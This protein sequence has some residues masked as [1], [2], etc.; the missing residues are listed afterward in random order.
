MTAIEP[1]PE[2]S[3]PAREP[4]R[5]LT[6][7]RS[8]P[9]SDTSNQL[10]QRNSPVDTGADDIEAIAAHCRA[11]A[12]AARW[13]AERQR[14][15]REK[16]GWTD[17][18]APADPAIVEWADKLTDSFYWSNASDSAG[19]PDIAMLDRVGG[20]FET[21]AEA[22]AF[23]KDEQDR[24]GG[25]ERALKL[26]AEAQA[27]LRESLRNLRAPDDP[28]QLA[29]Y[30]WLRA[31]AARHRIF[32]KRFMRADDRADPSD[33]PCLLARIETA[34]GSRPQSQRQRAMLDDLRNRVSHI[35][36]RGEG[37]GHDWQAV[38]QAVEDIVDA[39]IPP[40]N[41]EL[42]DLLLPVIDELPDQDGLPPGFRLVTR[43][44]DRYLARRQYTLTAAALPI[45]TE[46]VQQAARVLAGRSVVL[47][48]G[49]RRPDAQKM[50]RAA[51][52]LKDLVWIE[53][54][55]HQSIG[56]FESAVARPD[57]ALVLLAIRWS[58]HA[59]GDV[60]QFCD[61][62]GKPL[63]R[64]PGG[65]SPNQVAAQI[66]MQAGDRLGGNSPNS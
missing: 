11:K 49:V 9:T 44:V 56:R 59:F 20:C 66:I 39:G 1:G 5:E 31:T 41:R 40:S 58:S 62:Y 18:D 65:Y 10:E 51:L 7:G 60:Q 38:V 28:D 50:L 14:R 29:V 37:T 23:V 32:L 16:Y 3:R 30:E 19:L 26:L 25:L 22:L 48:G 63:V 61:Q 27:S 33:W 52:G 13:S 12:D 55:E 21:V 4:L 2:D 42:R 57:V 17:E 34:A 47:I 35:R 6:L 36:E 43:E 45:P 64:L 24:R 53:T 15:I 46:E 54:K 8:R